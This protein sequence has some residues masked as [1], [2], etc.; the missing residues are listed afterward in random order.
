MA[1]MKYRLPLREIVVDFYTEL[2][3][4][5]SGYAS[6]DYEDADYEASDLVKLDILLNGQPVD[7]MATI[8]H[9][10]K[11]QRV[12][13][14]PVEKLKKFIDRQM[15]EIT[16]QAAIGSKVIARETCLHMCQLPWVC[17]RTSSICVIMGWI[18]E[19]CPWIIIS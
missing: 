11:V 16:I 12:G 18:P 2:K 4:I 6:F 10:L 8:V 17:R 7:A 9:R 14:E 1:F 5:T 13:R 19:K 3:S 15:F